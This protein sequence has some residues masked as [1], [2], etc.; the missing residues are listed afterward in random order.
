MTADIHFSIILI[1][2]EGFLVCKACPVS[3]LK[4]RGIIVPRMSELLQRFSAAGTFVIAE[5]R[6]QQQ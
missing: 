6:C 3:P 5:G 2:A 1:R 4:F